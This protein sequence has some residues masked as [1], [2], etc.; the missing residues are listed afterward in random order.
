MGV[1]SCN[2]SNLMYAFTVFD[3][4]VLSY[5]IDVIRYDRSVFR[6]RRHCR[7]GDHRAVA[8]QSH[9]KPSIP[10]YFGCLS[11]SLTLSQSLS[12][13]SNFISHRSIYLSVGRFLSASLST[14]ISSCL[15]LPV[16]LYALLSLHAYATY[17]S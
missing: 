1:M 16:P 7:V 9:G 2:P 6:C 5:D 4:N 15:C 8:L 14:S 10:V 13:V 3:L 11:P 17:A 12:P